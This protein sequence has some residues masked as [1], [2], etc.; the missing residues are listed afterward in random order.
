M[1]ASN[2]LRALQRLRIGA[3]SLRNRSS[4]R[5]CRIFQRTRILYIFCRVPNI[6]KFSYIINPRLVRALLSLKIANKSFFFE[7]CS[8]ND[9]FSFRNMENSNYQQIPTQRFSTKDGFFSE[10][11]AVN[12]TR[13]PRQHTD[14]PSN[15]GTVITALNTILFL[16]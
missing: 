16:I 5:F 12:L 9:D 15:L 3:E 1:K 6:L 13:I 10:S 11:S 14:V 7:I 8:K 4:I 2:H